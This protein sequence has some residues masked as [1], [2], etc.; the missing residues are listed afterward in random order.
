MLKV[1]NMQKIKKTFKR[2]SKFIYNIT[3]E[4]LIKIHIFLGTSISTFYLLL[5]WK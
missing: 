2:Q 5:Q 1:E 3:L 4:V